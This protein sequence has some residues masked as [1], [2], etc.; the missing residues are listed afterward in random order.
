MASL[1][2]RRS[3]LPPF[4]DG[5]ATRV[6]EDDI[7]GAIGDTSAEADLRIED[8]VIDET[9]AGIVN[10]GNAGTVASECRNSRSRVSDG[11]Y[12]VERTGESSPSLFSLLR[13]QMISAF[14][15]RREAQR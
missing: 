9:D 12:A 3:E 10:F 1:P 14:R 6:T 4:T 11:L 15:L 13:G 7:D 2:P 5:A 8:D